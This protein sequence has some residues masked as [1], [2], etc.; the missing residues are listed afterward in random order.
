MTTTHPSI[1]R[2]PLLA[3]LVASALLLAGCAGMGGGDTRTRGPMNAAALQKLDDLVAR[4]TAAKRLPGAVVVLYRDGK[5]VHEKAIG[6][7]DPASPAPMT[8]DAIFRIYSMSKPIVSVGVM[9]L[10]EDGRVQL[11]APVSRYLPE[12]KDQK[13]GIEK[14]DASGNPVLELVPSPRQPTVQ[15]L[16]RHTSGLTYGVFGKSLIKSEY[17]KAGVEGVNLSNTDFSKRIGTMPL[18]SVP[19]TVWEYSRSTDVLGALIERVS[20]Q[21]LGVYLQQRILGP[22]GMKDSGFSVPAD[23]LNR[24]AEPYKIDPDSQQPVALIDITKPP[25]YESGG[26]GMVSTAGDYLRFCRMVLN[27]G[28][29][30]GVRILSPKTVDSMLSDHLGHDVIRASRVP[31]VNTGYLPGPGYGFGLGFAVR[32]A[33]GES[34]SASSVGESNWGGLG[35]TAF[36]IDPKE[37]LI[38]IWMMQAPGQREYYRAVFRNMVYGAF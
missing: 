28:E 6:V 3:T 23:K 7:R 2:R 18:A 15:D 30:D 24:I 16:L 10:V 5:V 22:L 26:G 32:L 37:K 34:P 11:Q 31:G 35:G 13:L 38:A 17:L 19:G 20:G 12:F 29:L 25:V 27:G 1:P 14:K 21:T 8:S 36:W 9:M 33:P 4:D